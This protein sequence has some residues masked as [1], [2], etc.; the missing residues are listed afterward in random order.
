MF[1]L[2]PSEKPWSD[3]Y[4]CHIVCHVCLFFC[5][6]EFVPLSVFALL[7]SGYARCDLRARMVSAG[8]ISGHDGSSSRQP[9]RTT[10]PSHQVIL[11]PTVTQS[12]S[13]S[14]DFFKSAFGLQRNG[15]SKDFLYAKAED[16]VQTIV[17]EGKCQCSICQKCIFTNCIFSNFFFPNCI[18]Q[19]E[20]SKL[21]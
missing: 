14:L 10:K 18:F 7:L 8:R 12:Q 16:V 17:K 20:F 15:S 21:L 3:V 1:V 11:A 5:N 2:F 4:H 19:I 9:G 13:C 6:L